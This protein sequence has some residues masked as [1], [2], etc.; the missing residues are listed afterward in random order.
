MQ[1][2]QPLTEKALIKHLA[3][4]DHLLDEVYTDTSAKSALIRSYLSKMR[5]NRK[6][7]LTAI[8]G[9]NL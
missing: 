5:C 4:I 3:E 7:L 9:V 1:T 8:D 2:R 6:E